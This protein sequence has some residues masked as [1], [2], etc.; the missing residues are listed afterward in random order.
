MARDIQANLLP[1][2]NPEISGYDIAGMSLA[3][4]NVG[5]DYYIKHYTFSSIWEDMVMNFLNHEM[6]GDV[7][8]KER[9]KFGNDKNGV[10]YRKTAEIDHFFLD[11]KNEKVYI[12]DS[13]YKTKIK[14]FDYKQFSYS[15]IIKNY[16]AEIGKSGYTIKN[17]LI[18]PN[19]K[20]VKIESYFEWDSIYYKEFIKNIK[21]EIRKEDIRELA[22][23][24]LVE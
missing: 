24:Y 7:F 20:P 13:K 2:S 5:G 15:V 9:K 4:L 8:K 3:A 18:L 23:L 14:E 22:E 16:L 1:K 10:N 19:E 11:D 21:I 6:N 17:C 12:Y